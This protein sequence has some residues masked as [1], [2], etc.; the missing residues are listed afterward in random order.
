MNIGNLPPVTLRAA[1]LNAKVLWFAF[2]LAPVIYV[3]AG[4]VLRAFDDTFAKEGFNPIGDAIWAARAGLVGWWFITSF[5]AHRVIN[6]QTYLEKTATG[7]A[8]VTDTVIAAAMQ[9]ALVLRFAIIESVAI[10]GFLLFTFNGE[11]IEYAFSGL[12]LVNMFLIRPSEDKWNAAFR[13]AAMRY[14]GVSSSVS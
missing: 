13:D 3:I 6:E 4:E 14:P 5:I 7:G 9:T 1:L 2:S 11:R 12:A 10:M 8:E